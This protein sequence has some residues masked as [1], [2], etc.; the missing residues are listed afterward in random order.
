M[1]LRSTLHDCLYLNWAVPLDA[2][3]GPPESLRYDRRDS[4]DGPVVFASALLFRQH[5]LGVQGLP[6]PRLDAPQFELHLCTVD[7][8]GVPSTLVVSVLVPLWIAAGSRWVSRQ[9]A[10][11]ARLEYPASTAD[12]PRWRWRVQRS[13][14]LLVEGEAG[15]PGVGAGPSLGTWD[16][17]VAYFRRR[18]VA[19]SSV[20]GALVR[21]DIRR[22]RVGVTPVRAEVLE[23][24]LLVRELPGLG[25][26]G[27]PLLHSA[28]LCGPMDVVY[29]TSGAERAVVG[30]QVPAPG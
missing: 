14:G 6:L 23:N 28:W 10:R 26:T 1:I 2:L 30:S 21:T 5:G 4:A 11:G 22:P 13:G 24:A 19:Y 7:S 29:D 18:G 17:T 12:S 15:A 9:P 20:S 25:D 27:V 16:Q 8:A 3:P